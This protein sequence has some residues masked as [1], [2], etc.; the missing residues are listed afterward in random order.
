MT[1]TLVGSV[2]LSHWIDVGRVPKDIDYFSDKDVSGAETF[3][4]DRLAFWEFRD[5][6][7]LDEL[8]TIKVSHSF[9]DLHGT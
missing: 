1:K 4:D 7:T 8:Y 5:V 2:A 9:W 6:A 3:W